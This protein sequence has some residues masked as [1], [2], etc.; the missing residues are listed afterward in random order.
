MPHGAPHWL[1]SP[2]PLRVWALVTLDTARGTRLQTSE[3]SAPETS[4]K[5]KP[6]AAILGF[7]FSSQKKVSSFSS[8]CFR[9]K[10]LLGA[11]VMCWCV[12]CVCVCVVFCGCVCVCVCVCVIKHCQFLLGHSGC[13]PSTA[14][15]KRK[16]ENNRT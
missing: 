3:R 14:S 1:L 11:V 6:R 13:P 16:Q 9:P 2:S 8:L 10:F 4:C 5:E 12:C 15:K 7:C